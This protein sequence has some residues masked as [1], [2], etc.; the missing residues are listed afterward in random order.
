[1]IGRFARFAGFKLKRTRYG[2]YNA[3]IRD[4]FAQ[5]ISFVGIMIAQ[6]EHELE[7][8]P[9][10]ADTPVVVVIA[11]PT[12]FTLA[13]TGGFVPLNILVPKLTSE[14]KFLGQG[15]FQNAVDVMRLPVFT[16]EVR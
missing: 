8:F 6:I 4:I 1:L 13:V 14:N 3:L 7:Q 15:E 2:E 10:N 12:V 16:E 9:G 5:E 11:I